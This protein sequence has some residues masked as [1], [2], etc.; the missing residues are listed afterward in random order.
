MSRVRL[1][2]IVIGGEDP[3]EGN[4]PPAASPEEIGALRE[5]AASALEAGLVFIEAH[6]EELTRLRVRTLL[7][8]ETRETCAAEIEAYQ[9]DNGSFPLLGL[10]RGGAPG[11]AAARVAGLAP[12]V[13]GTLEALVALSDLGLHHH[14]C[15]DGAAVFLQSIQADDGTWG[16]SGGPPESRLFAT[17]MLA[18]LLGR[19]RVV[20]P[21]LLEAAGEYL[22]SIFNPEKISGRQWESLTAFG[23]FFT[24]VG[25]D[26]ADS[27]LQWIGRELERGYRTRAYD[28]GLTVRTLLHC[29]SLAVPGASL[30]PALLLIDLLAEQATDGGFAEFSEGNDATRVEPTLDAMLGTI[31]LSRA[32]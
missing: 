2:G 22:G 10:A 19:T 31:L 23:V 20:R 25:H 3:E 6:G 27:A 18:G 14:P 29:Q 21:E 28:A 13:L 24:N 15:I 11:L 7:G 32:L 5:R 17:G 1:E 9:A 8:A 16:A 12:E 4:A 30:D 26:L